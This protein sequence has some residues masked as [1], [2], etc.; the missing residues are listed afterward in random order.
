MFGLRGVLSVTAGCY[1][2]NLRGVLKKL[3]GVLKYLRPVLKFLRTYL[4]FLRWATVLGRK[5]SDGPALDKGKWAARFVAR[6]PLKVNPGT[7]F[8][9]TVR[10]G[11]K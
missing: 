4:K 9:V 3:R 11:V 7:G 5:A 8:Y 10:D 1:L 6:R 2:K